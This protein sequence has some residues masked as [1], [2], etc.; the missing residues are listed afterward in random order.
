MEKEIISTSNAPGA[1]GPYSQAVKVGNILYTSG[2]LPIVPATGELIKYDIKRATTQCLENIKGILDEV[3]TSFDKVIKTMIFL[4]DMEDFEAVN[5]VYA[6]YFA[7]K[8]PARSCVQ[9][10]K[11][12]KNAP[13]EIE[14]I[15]LVD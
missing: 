15:A 2:Q 10:S 3:G 7:V 14:V 12:P 5:E 1:I 6:K 11:L 13:I 4:R 9:V 8:Q